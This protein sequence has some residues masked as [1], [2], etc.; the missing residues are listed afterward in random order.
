MRRYIVLTII[1][2]AFAAAPLKAQNAGTESQVD[3]VVYIPAASMDASLAGKDVFNVVTVHQSQAI[4]DAMKGKIERN[5][6]R[7]MTGYRVRIFFDNKQNARSASEAAMGRFQAAYPG[8]GVYRSFASPYF[9]VTVGDFRTKSEAMQ[10]MRRIKA[11]VPAA[12]V[13]K[14]NINYP[15]VDRDHAY[16]V[17]TVS[18][19]RP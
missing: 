19:S 4:A 3:S 15:I 5:K 8:H 6:S 2:A 9:K 16:D 18:V 1:V 11:D 13:V 17:D 10:M 14:E 7:R 12:F